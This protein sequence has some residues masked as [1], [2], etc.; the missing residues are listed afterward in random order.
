MSPIDILTEKFLLKRTGAFSGQHGSSGSSGGGGRGSSGSSG[1]SS[2]SGGSTRGGSG[3]SGSSGS[4]TPKGATSGSSPAKNGIP[5]KTSSSTYYG[6]GSPK[7]ISSGSPFAGR[8]YGGGTR[9]NIYSGS[10]Y[11]TGYGSYVSG[12]R[13]SGGFYPVRGYG[14]PFGFWPLYLGPTYYQDDEYGPPTNDSRPGGPQAVASFSPPGVAPYAPPQY[15]VFG[16]Q[17]SVAN[18]SSL[19]VSNCSAV[20]TVST[21]LLNS[22]MTYPDG[23]NVTL[24]PAIDPTYIDGYYRASSFALFSFFQGEVVNTSA[25]LV[26]FTEPATKPTL[27]DASVRNST[28]ESCVNDTIS[29]GLPIEAGS[30]ASVSILFLGSESRTLTLCYMQGRLQPSLALM[31]LTILSS[32]LVGG[33]ITILLAVALVITRLI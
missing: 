30:F 25:A 2:S 32:A 31:P 9:S 27:Y 24:L 11:G 14:F 15:M 4:T 16:D 29:N 21:T 19:L 33:R 18:V 6:G 12:T 28:F 20:T 22:D 5:G 1:S 17:G 7:T 10:G 8:S 26:N 13:S 3:S 23:T